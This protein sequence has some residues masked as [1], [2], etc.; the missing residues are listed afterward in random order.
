MIKSLKLT[1]YKAFYDFFLEF[2]QKNIII[3]PNNA[4]KST[5]MEALSLIAYVTRTTFNREIKRIFHDTIHGDEVHGFNFSYDNVSITTVNIKHNFLDEPSIIEAAF[6]EGIKAIIVFPVDIDNE[7]PFCYFEEYGEPLTD[8]RYIK[9]ILKTQIG[10]IP[11]VGP[12]EIDEDL[13]QSKYVKS[14]LNSRLAPR[15]F[16]NYWYHFPDTF[17]DFKNLINEF[18]PKIGVSPPELKVGESKL[19]MF[20]RE[21]VMHCE[22]SWAGHGL[23][24]WLQVLTHYVRLKNES[25]LVFDEPDI[26]LHSDLQRKL[27]N[28]VY[29]TE[30]Q[31]IIA[32]HSV[33][34]IK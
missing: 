31:I 7:L 1:R 28:I 12:L 9:S 33:D 23:Q 22:L 27:I 30:Q 10:I 16:R 18:T 32:T 13:L 3:G 26:Y 17:N 15:H 19:E 24:I 21:G 5:I 25:C 11:T 6:T 29:P 20:F 2:Q 8:W 14:S 34:I 4:G